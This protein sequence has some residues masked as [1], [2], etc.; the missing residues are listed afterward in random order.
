MKRLLFLAVCCAMSGAVGQQTDAP[1]KIQGAR[2]IFLG[3][4][5]TSN[6]G[7]LGPKRGYYH[8]TDVLKTRFNLETVNLGKGGSRAD[9]G[10]ERLRQT[11]SAGSF[12]PDFVIINFGMNDH[13]I[14]EKTKE[15]VSSNEAFEKQLGD[16]V[17]LVRKSGATPILVAPH[18]IFEGE[19]GNKHSYYG[20]Y[21]PANFTQYG[22]A[23]ARFD[24]FIE[25]I[26]KVAAA[27]DV[28]LVDIR[29]ESD[30]YNRA[31]YTLEGVH[32]NKSGHQMYADTIGNFLAAH[33]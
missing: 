21:D 28:P 11:L 5:L 14:A 33:Y 8:W 6:N 27:R 1:R 29:K 15:P 22:G 16:I 12:K 23:L 31:D 2:V 17:D 10:L 7:N 4:S 9:A 24:T 32:L 13:K 19:K 3:D 20:K 25:S 30:K 18:A 26:R